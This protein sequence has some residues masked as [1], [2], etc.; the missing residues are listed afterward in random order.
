M[1]EAMRKDELWSKLEKYADGIA[2]PQGVVDP[3]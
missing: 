1:H 2:A 3:T